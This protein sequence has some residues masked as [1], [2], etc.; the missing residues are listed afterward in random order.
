[1][2]ADA[3]I[4]YT[5]IEL[6]ITGGSGGVPVYGWSSSAPVITN[7]SQKNPPNGTLA[8]FTST[9]LPSNACATRDVASASIV[10][11]VTTFEASNASAP[12]RVI[13]A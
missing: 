13:A 6:S 1:M 11:A 3:G 10:G 4:V 7:G 12:G 5:A 8:G 2:S 9:A